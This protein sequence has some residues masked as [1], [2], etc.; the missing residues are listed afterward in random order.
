MPLD[1]RAKPPNVGE[2]YIFQPA[3]GVGHGESHKGSPLTA[4][5]TALDL[6]PGTEVLV[7]EIEE[8]TGRPILDWTDSTGQDRMTSFDPD[9]F[10]GDFQPI[11]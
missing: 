9:E 8:A 1:T 11:P 6:A 4:E 3:D 2:R 7:Y 5:M 10:S